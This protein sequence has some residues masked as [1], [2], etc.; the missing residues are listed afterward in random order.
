MNES[1]M[2]TAPRDQPAEWHDYVAN[3]L[4]EQETRMDTLESS[5][6]ANT[7][8]TARVEANTAGIVEMM[9][10]WDG[11]MKTIASI[12]KFLKPLTYIVS[13]CT[14]VL[15]LWISAKKIWGGE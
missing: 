1:D 14:A 7:T 15:A 11:A 5:L 2:K 13:F 10:S 9:N 6:H 4:R 3:K 12:G 8:A